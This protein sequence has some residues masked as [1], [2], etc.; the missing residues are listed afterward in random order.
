MRTGRREWGQEKSV[1][2]AVSVT[3]W[4][5]LGA[6]TPCRG[7]AAVQGSGFC[8]L[9][10]RPCLEFLASKLGVVIRHRHGGGCG[11]AELGCVRGEQGQEKWTEMLP[12]RQG[13]VEFW[14]PPRLAQAYSLAAA[15]P[16]QQCWAVSSYSVTASAAAMYCS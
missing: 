11:V 4:V 15:P 1:H 14:Q 12:S 3:R 10:H 6:C 13:V 2:P 7:E 16:C 8:C 9:C 5:P